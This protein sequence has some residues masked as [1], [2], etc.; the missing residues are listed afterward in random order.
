MEMAAAMICLNLVLIL[1]ALVYG[2]VAL[3]RGKVQF[4]RS[5]TLHGTKAR[6]AGV[7]CIVVGIL[8]WWWSG[9]MW[10]VFDR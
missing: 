8:F 5:R 10:A 2:L 7:L 9:K 1:A 6:M 4:T 3:I